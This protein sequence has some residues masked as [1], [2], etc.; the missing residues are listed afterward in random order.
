MQP[1]ALQRRVS[2]LLCVTRTEAGSAV[3]ARQA[4]RKRRSVQVPLQLALPGPGAASESQGVQA[5]SLRLSGHGWLLHGS[6]SSGQPGHSAPP[7]AGMGL[8][9]TR[10]RTLKPPPQGAEHS[11][12]TDHGLQPPS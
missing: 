12:Q 5:D 9:Q 11:P 4:N 1:L 6:W 8:S 3:C 2:S 10:R 7:L